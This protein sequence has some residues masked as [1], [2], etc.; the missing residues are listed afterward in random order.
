MRPGNDAVRQKI[1][2]IGQDL[3]G[4]RFWLFEPIRSPAALGVGDRLLFGVEGELHPRLHVARARPARQRITPSRA[5]SWRA[6]SSAL[7]TIL[8]IAGETPEIGARLPVVSCV[9]R[10][11]SRIPSDPVVMLQRRGDAATLQTA[12]DS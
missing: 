9:A 10:A 5:N 11:K 4:D 1:V 2:G 3:A 7:R 6:P 12:V 8:G